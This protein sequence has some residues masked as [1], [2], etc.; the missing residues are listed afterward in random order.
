MASSVCRYLRYFLWFRV[1]C[2]VP[3]GLLFRPF[4]ILHTNIIGTLI[5]ILRYPII[6]MG[7]ILIE[8]F[9]SMAL[10]HC[11]INTTDLR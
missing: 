8:R 1:L 9:Y 7:S 5:H 3:A 6:L 10:L 2:Q 4:L 11:R